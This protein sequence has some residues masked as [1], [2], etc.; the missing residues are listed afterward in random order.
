MSIPA[1][2]HALDVLRT[3]MF[4]ALPPVTAAADGVWRGLFARVCCRR[5][6]G[7]RHAD[8]RRRA[9]QAQCAHPQRGKQMNKQITT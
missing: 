9:R 6:A 3:H 7:H 4:P 1:K 5:P 2:V 8:G